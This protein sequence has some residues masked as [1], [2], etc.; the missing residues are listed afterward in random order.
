MESYVKNLHIQIYATTDFDPDLFADS[1]MIY[2]LL[3]NA[4][5][6][7]YELFVLACGD[8]SYVITSG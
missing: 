5:S 6:T 2:F 4:P 8:C 3:G 7:I 1:Y